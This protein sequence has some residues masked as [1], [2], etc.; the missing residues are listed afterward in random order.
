MKSCFPML[1]LVMMGILIVHGYVIQ[2]TPT[3]STPQKQQQQPQL[4]PTEAPQHRRLVKRELQQTL[5]LYQDWHDICNDD[6]SNA[7]VNVV[8]PSLQQLWQTITTTVNCGNGYIKTK[9]TT[10]TATA[11]ATVYTGNPAPYQCVDKCWSDY[12]W[13]TYG[14]SI[15]VAQGFTGIVLIIIGLYLGLFGYR[16]FRPTMGL[17]GFIFI[18]SM[19]WIGL[20]N[21]EPAMGYPHPEIVYICVSIGLGI[22]GA[23]AFMFMFNV[24]LYFVGAVAGLFLAVFIMSWRESLV[25]Q[26]KVARICF[27]VGMGVVL[28]FAVYLLE[29][30][31][32]ILSTAFLGAYLFIMGLDFFAH[33]GFVNAWR[34]LFDSNPNHYNAYI[35]ETPTYVMLAFVILLCII[36]AIWQYYWNIVKLKRRFGVNVTEKKSEKE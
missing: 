4:Y 22:I 23:I 7:K 14:S 18:A 28:A 24:A 16:F 5:E 11:T 26:V 9:T 33:T 10:I 32:V 3:P 2:P 25:I 36:S 35:I 19:T 1:V 17:V 21:N 6:D 13:Y 29:C 31:I 20:A 27:T 15:S 30:Y 8:N 34:L 12:L